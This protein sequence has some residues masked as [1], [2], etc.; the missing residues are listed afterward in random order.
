MIDSARE[1]RLPPIKGNIEPDKLF[2]HLISYIPTSVDIPSFG[3]AVILGEKEWAR[4]AFEY[5]R[6][7]IK[8]L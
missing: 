2:R 3:R 7:L 1:E 5:L 6:R 8:S 4:L